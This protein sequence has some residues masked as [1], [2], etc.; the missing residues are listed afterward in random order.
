M[1]LQKEE[2]KK[3]IIF[4]G[5]AFQF[6]LSELKKDK[7]IKLIQ[8]GQQKTVEADVRDILQR[9]LR[10]CVDIEVGGTEWEKDYLDIYKE[11]IDL[12]SKDN[13]QSKLED[14]K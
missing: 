7:L 11:V 6:S 4:S 10:K 14:H 5:K 9:G 12:V 3:Y 2:I 13:P 8:Q 1:V